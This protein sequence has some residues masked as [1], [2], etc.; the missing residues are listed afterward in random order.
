MKHHKRIIENLRILQYSEFRDNRKQTNKTS[1]SILISPQTTGLLYPTTK[2]TRSEKSEKK[3]W[4]K[5]KK[6]TRQEIPFMGKR[7]ERR[8]RGEQ[9]KRKGNPELETLASVHVIIMIDLEAVLSK[10]TTQPSNRMMDR[11][12]VYLQLRFYYDW[13]G[14]SLV[15]GH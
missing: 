9:G 4:W 2:M 8:R 6:K 1:M 7:T 11:L 15:N 14:R 13:L 5:K 10:R 3:L 12:M